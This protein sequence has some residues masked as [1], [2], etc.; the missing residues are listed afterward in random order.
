MRNWIDSGVGIL[1][2]VCVCVCGFV[3]IGWLW[4]VYNRSPSQSSSSSLT[5]AAAAGMRAKSGT[6]R[7]DQSHVTPWSL[8]LALPPRHSSRLALF[9]FDR[10]LLHLPFHLSVNRVLFCQHCL[11]RAVADFPLPLVKS[12][13]LL[14]LELPQKLASSTLARPAQAFDFLALERMC[15][16]FTCR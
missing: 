8:L 4:V 5:V 14:L 2:D 1:G 10:V 9:L 15:F 7:V 13:H 3:W 6:A 16:Q 12:H 11:G